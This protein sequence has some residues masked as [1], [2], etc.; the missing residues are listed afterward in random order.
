M[1]DLN[2]FMGH[3]FSR[4]TSESVALVPTRQK[5]APRKHE[6]RGPHYI[7]MLCYAHSLLE[8]KLFNRVAQGSSSR[9]LNFIVTTCDRKQRILALRILL[10]RRNG[11]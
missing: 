11:H 3:W 10:F 6:R 8:L 2:V 1:S 7:H 9:S 4:P 5:L